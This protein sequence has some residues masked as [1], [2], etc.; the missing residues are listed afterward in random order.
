MSVHK[1]EA[2]MIRESLGDMLRSAEN[3]IAY[4]KG[5]GA[6]L[7]Y[8]AALMLFAVCDA[9]GSHYERD[10]D[11]KVEIDGTVQ[12]VAKEHFRILNG[13]HYQLNL[14]GKFIKFLTDHFRNPLAHH[15]LIERCCVLFRNHSSGEPFFVAKTQD[16]NVLVVAV[17]LVPF[18][19]VTKRAVEAFLSDVDSVIGKE[20]NQAY[21]RSR[22]EYGKLTVAELQ[23]STWH[24]DII[25]AN[26]VTG[27]YIAP[28]SL[29][30]SF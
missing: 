8:P 21:L 7:G 12:P 23:P 14:T 24:T 19:E 22:S 20:R 4:D 28:G 17:N 16:E 11:F 9:I 1:D 13:P 25:T 26:C 27:F 30:S 6:C 15:A 10:P 3:D 2:C 18:L 5:D 29:E